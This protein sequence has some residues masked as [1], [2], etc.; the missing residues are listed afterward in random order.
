MSLRRAQFPFVCGTMA[1]T[2]AM[3]SRLR[4]AATSLAPILAAALGVRLLFLYD[5]VRQNP[6][7]ALGVIPFLFESG[8]IVPLP[9]VQ[10]DRNLSQGC[11]SLI[12]VYAEIGEALVCD[13]VSSLDLSLC[14]GIHPYT[15]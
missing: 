1:G 8:D 10:A 13:A 15:Y 9:A 12:S 4:A 14:W 5:Y 6:H 11:Q 7:H 2:R 3:K